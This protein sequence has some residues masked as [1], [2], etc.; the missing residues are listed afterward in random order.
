[1]ARSGDFAIGLLIVG[2]CFGVVVTYS[3]SSPFI[4]EKAFGF[5]AVVTGY[6]SLLSGF[7]IMVGGIIAKSLIK[8]P[9]IK[10]VVTALVIQVILV[11]LMIFTVPLASNIF[12]LIGFTM[13][14]HISGGFI[15]NIIYG[16]CMS[17]FT[18]N[19]GV[20][21]GITGGSM[22][23]LSSLFSYGF[24]N[25]Y[26]I[27]SQFLLGVANASLITMIIVLFAFFVP[28]MKLAKR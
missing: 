21:S 15:F 10:K 27:K 16:Y 6:G 28:A 22:Y 3:L 26:A 11:L 9:L 5:S 12:S 7:S 19:A 18:K 25:L 20:A 2:V 24:A 1:M 17:R 4:I 13:C 14:I 8:K 23:M